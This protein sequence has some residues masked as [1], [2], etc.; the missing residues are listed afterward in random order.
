MK[1]LVL[2]LGL[3]GR[4][5]KTNPLSYGG[6]PP[7]YDGLFGSNVWPGNTTT[8]TKVIRLFF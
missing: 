6:T 4:Q 2:K 8:Y 7:Q 5:A 1:C 3:P